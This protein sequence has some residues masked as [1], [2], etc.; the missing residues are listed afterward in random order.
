VGGPCFTVARL[1]GSFKPAQEA[2]VADMFLQDGPQ[3]GVV[4]M[5]EASFEGS[6]HAPVRPYPNV[7]AFGEGC[8]ASP[9]RSASVALGGAWGFLGGFEQRAYAGLPPFIRPSRPAAWPFS[10]LGLLLQ[11]APSRGPW[12]LF[13]ADCLADLRHLCR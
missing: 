2:I 5:L 7:R 13:L 1:Q 12:P 10:S 8:L 11:E 3:D 9:V 4:D 6:C